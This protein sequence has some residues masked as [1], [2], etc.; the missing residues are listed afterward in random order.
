MLK[1]IVRL[2]IS[3]FL[4]YACNNPTTA[5]QTPKVD[6]N[7]CPAPATTVTTQKLSGSVQGDLKEVASGNLNFN[8]NPEI[9]ELVSKSSND[10][11]VTA[12]ILCT[13]QKGGFS[14]DQALWYLQLINY[15]SS[16][17]PPTA[18]QLDA[19]YK[20]F[21]PPKSETVKVV[22]IGNSGN[23]TLTP[24]TS[25]TTMPPMIPITPLT[26]TAPAT[27]LPTITSIPIAIPISTPIP[28]ST[29]TPNSISTPI[30]TTTP[31]PTVIPLP[32]PSFYNISSFS[33]TQGANQW[34]YYYWDGISYQDLTFNSNNTWIPQN[35]TGVGISADGLHPPAE[36][37]KAI[38]WAWKSKLDGNINISA[39][40]RK[41]A[42]NGGDGIKG[43]YFH[44]TTKIY[45]KSI[46]FND[47]NGD[48]F[49]SNID[50]KQ[51][52]TIYFR[53][54]NNEHNDS[55]YDSGF[56]YIRISYN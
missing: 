53:V 44:N 50:V 20:K 3:L 18:D 54:N 12:Y 19:W 23:S 22:N 34:Y 51:G 31:T 28:T 38:T 40:L 26:T 1:K 10:N 35:I 30:S 46:A 9:K 45:E 42:I 56:L 43:I 13:A 37:Q 32:K 41:T 52:D 27:P 47:N 49:K 33:N 24:A 29:P 14:V 15:K 16:N 11:Q 2:N 17:P 25:V 39:N 5:I 8:Y 48:T 4:L 6:E 36:A 7:G 21:P 55:G